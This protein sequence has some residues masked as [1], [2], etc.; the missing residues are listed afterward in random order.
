RTENPY[1]RMEKIRA[2]VAKATESNIQLAELEWQRVSSRYGTRPFS[3]Q[4][5]VNVK[6][7]GD[8][9]IAI[10][11]YIA[12][13]DERT[14]TRYSLNHEIVKLLHNGEELIPGDE[15]LADT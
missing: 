5:T 11:R 10:V 14:A 13:A 9:V 12:R 4:P 6:P 3:A 7:T 2:I 1:P 8:G 15:A